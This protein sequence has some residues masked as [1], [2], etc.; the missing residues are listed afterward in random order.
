MAF[1][2]QSQRT[3]I[4]RP[5]PFGTFK[6]MPMVNGQI[7]QPNQRRLMRGKAAGGGWDDSLLDQGYDWNPA[8]QT[9]EANGQA[10]SGDPPNTVDNSGGSDGVTDEGSFNFQSNEGGSGTI[11]DGFG[12]G[13]AIGGTALPFD[14]S[15]FAIQPKF[16]GWNATTYNPI[17]AEQAKVI[18]PQ[19]YASKFGEFNRG[20]FKKN[21]EQG[22]NYGLDALRNELKGL[23]TFTPEAAKLARSETSSDNA[24]NQEA[25]TS[26]VNSVLPD[27]R[28]TFDRVKGTLTDQAGRASI[29]TQG[30]LL[31]DQQNQALELGIRSDAADRAS[32]GGFGARSSQSRK[33][34]DLMSARERF[35]ISQYGENLTS[36]N[37][38]AQQGVVA[39]EAN[40]FLAPTSYSQVGQQ[41]R[42]TPEVGA[43]R[44]GLQAAGMVNEATML[45]PAQALT[46]SIG[47]EQ[48]NTN[49]RQRTN[50]FNA[51]NTLQNDQFNAS[52]QFN[53]DTFNSQL[54]YNAQ[55]AMFGYAQTFAGQVQGANQ[56]ILNNVMEAQTS[57]MAVG[58]GQAGLANGQSAQTISSAIQGAGIAGPAISQLGSIF[59]GETSSA[60]PSV[61]GASSVGSTQVDTTPSNVSKALETPSSGSN[62]VDS[63]S[64]A[65]TPNAAP[66]NAAGVDLGASGAYKFAPGAAVPSGYTPISN[67]PDGTT[68]AVNPAA[69]STDAQQ[70]SKAFSSNASAIDPRNIAIMDQKI[71]KAAGITFGP[72][73]G[74]RPIATTMSGKTVYSSPQAASD[75][76]LNVGADTLRSTALSL[77]QL[78]ITDESMLREITGLSNEVSNPEFLGALNGV[79]NSKGP[80]AVSAAIMNKLMG[81]IPKSDSETKQQIIAGASRLGEIWQNL[82]PAQQSAA[83]SSLASN[84]VEAKTGK[85][86][87]K[88][89]VPGTNSIVG[90]LTSGEAM[91]AVTRGINGF[92]A[93][94]NWT[95]ATAILDMAG[96]NGLPNKNVAFNVGSQLGMFGIGP[97]GAATTSL[98]DMKISTPAPQ[99]GV[100]AM[101]VPANAAVPKDYEAVTTT[102]DGAKVIIPTANKNTSIF[103][104]GS[105]SPL[106]YKKAVSMANGE[107]KAMTLWGR[108]PS[109]GMVRGSAGGSAMMSALNAIEQGNPAL[110]SATVA[111]SF[112]NNTIGND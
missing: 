75:G 17:N 102:P 73:P 5:Q 50:E 60:N 79:A 101:L 111:H 4:R 33:T 57:G 107:H 86:I 16:V 103:N 108:S 6:Q 100:G 25:R 18:D 96:E 95:Q 99:L 35:N 21:F 8:T 97:Q 7:A 66:I 92:G 1:Q 90:P 72:T 56:G 48:N 13:G 83:L 87:S 9:Y 98:P 91:T 34:S 64:T 74:A 49:L 10:P 3:Q 76:N 106:A 27:A 24:F 39:N 30:K 14:A 15:G 61:G 84:V 65:P 2:S 69:Y 40:L 63:V 19:Q 112:F 37:T 93:A 32:F 36:A 46:S 71:S 110:Y 80:E 68:T 78:G 89:E 29:Y 58:M 94:R 23:Q 104:S 26:Q 44:L 54:D 43:G 53:A 12:G 28:S 51:S 42:V 20:E 77:A 88:M 31:D 105:V 11:A 81:E 47:Q 70:F 62:Q 109:R 85:N 55:A 67:N 41:V 45:S 22:L 52:G 59:S 82:S 38:N